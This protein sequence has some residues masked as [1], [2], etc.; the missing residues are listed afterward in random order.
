MDKQI[1]QLINEISIET[2]WSQP[3]IAVEVGT[4]QPTIN[5]IM[6][7]QGDCRISTYLAILKV[8]TTVLASAERRAKRQSAQAAK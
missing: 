8:H 6:R 4:S 5:R 7:G 3:R 2:G 1:S